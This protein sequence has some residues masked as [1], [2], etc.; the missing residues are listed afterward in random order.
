MEVLG[1]LELLEELIEK[2]KSVPMSSK[3]VVDR[4]EVLE[5]VKEIRMK[6]PEDI[7][8]AKWLKDE[9]QRIL[10][11][12]Q[13]EAENM[14]KEAEGQI[15]K[16]VDENEITQKAYVEAENIINSAKQSSQEIKRGT[17]EYVDST[18]ANAQE[19]L[20]KAYEVLK[21]DRES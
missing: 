3:C 16:M 2:A 21:K 6:L 11:E 7:K 9:R 18:L 4:E 12:A 20:Y 15:A 1:V 5:M 14:V 17:K 13:S 19:M 8:Q 10:A